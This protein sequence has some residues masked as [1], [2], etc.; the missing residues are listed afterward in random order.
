MTDKLRKAA[1]QII[2]AWNYGSPFEKYLVALDEALDHSGETNEMV[3]PDGY[4]LISIDALKAWGKYGELLNACLFPAEQ[5]EQEPVAF[6]SEVYQSR[7]TLEWNG[8]SL[9]VGAPLYDHSNSQPVVQAEQE[10]VL[11]VGDSSFEDWYQAHPKASGG[12]KQL[13]RDAYAAG[14]GDPL[15]MPVQSTSQEHVTCDSVRIYTNGY[16]TGYDNGLKAAQQPVQQEPVCKRCHGTKL[17]S[18]GEI[19]NIGGAP[20]EVPIECVK[21]CPDCSVPV[22]QVDLTYSQKVDKQPVIDVLIEAFGI[23]MASESRDQALNEIEKLATSIRTGIQKEK[24]KC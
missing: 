1:Q 19:D 3:A 7:Y 12:D 10:P 21:D 14:M 11:H 20:L 15:V 22:Q 16:N 9:P 2:D 4:A 17:V 18:D 24:N 23:V 5:A 13:A 6:V 8:R